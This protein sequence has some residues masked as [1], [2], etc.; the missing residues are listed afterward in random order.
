MKRLKIPDVT[1]HRLSDY[2]RIL[3]QFDEEGIRIV[4]SDVL[5]AR[6][7]LNPAQIRK[8]LAYFGEFGVRGVGY[9]V[10]ELKENLKGI[11]GVTHAWRVALVGAGNLGSA[12]AAYQGF[13]THGFIITAVFD[14]YPEQAKLPP[15]GRFPKILGV[16]RIKAEIRRRGIQIGIITVPAEAAQ[17]VA[18]RLVS[19]GISGILNFAPVR[20]RVPKHVKVRNVDLGSELESLSFFL[21]KQ[22]G[23]PS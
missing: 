18:E 1:V 10:G 21:S 11:L 2:A 5:A 12:L 17:G 20:L 7:G 14:K 3:D 23:A 22:G 4:S 13:L 16:D 8:D 19:A 9:H 15:N 6:C